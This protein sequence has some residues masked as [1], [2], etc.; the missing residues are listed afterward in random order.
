MPEVLS[1][2]AADA[3]PTVYEIVG[4][5]QKKTTASKIENS[6]GTPRS[7]FKINRDGA[8]VRVS[9]LDGAVQ[10]VVLK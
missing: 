1:I 9:K 2:N 3:P 10:V 7:T 8:L 6:V 4:G 5:K